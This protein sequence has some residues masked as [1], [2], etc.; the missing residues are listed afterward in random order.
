[1]E[2]NNDIVYNNVNIMLGAIIGTSA[3]LNDNVAEQLNNFNK[4]I[5][6]EV[7]NE[8]LKN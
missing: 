1:M 3:L 6:N 8:A 4:V 5:A 7:I 2:E